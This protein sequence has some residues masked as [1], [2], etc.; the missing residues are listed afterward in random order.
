MII[1][2]CGQKCE[3]S[4]V[5]YRLI[6]DYQALAITV[7][8]NKKTKPSPSLGGNGFAVKVESKYTKKTL[9][10]Q[11]NIERAIA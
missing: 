1:P 11:E 5:A 4:R 6:I 3:N 2:L 10:A 7:R 8:A 9:G